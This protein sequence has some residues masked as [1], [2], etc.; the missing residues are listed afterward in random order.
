MGKT[1]KAKSGEGYDYTYQWD[2]Q[3]WV[4]T[5]DPEERKNLEELNAMKR[6]MA[7][8]PSASHPEMEGS[9]GYLDYGEKPA[10]AEKSNVP[11]VQPQVSQN[12]EMTAE[13]QRIMDSINRPALEPAQNYEYNLEMPGKPASAQIDR[14]IEGRNI[15]GSAI[16]KTVNP[17][18]FLQ[19]ALRRLMAKRGY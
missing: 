4:R 11:S 15:N 2:N 13:R 8:S 7:W 12:N 14:Q 17:E 19:S 9:S 18:S 16:P 5:E 6:L 10:Y 3:P 1:I